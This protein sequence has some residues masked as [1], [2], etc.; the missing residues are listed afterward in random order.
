MTIVKTEDARFPQG[1]AIATVGCAVGK[2]PASTHLALIAD[3]QRAGVDALAGTA[4]E[5]PEGDRSKFFSP[6]LL[7][8]TSPA[9][10]MKSISDLLVFLDEWRKSIRPERRNI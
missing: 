4:A 3:G 2:Y 1:N 8:P 7:K 10:E 9:K 5:V 6:E